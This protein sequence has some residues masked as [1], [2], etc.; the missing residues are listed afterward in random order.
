M[1]TSRTRLSRDSA[2]TTPP[3]DRQRAA[4][5]AGAVAARDERHAVAMAQ[6]HD[7]PAP[8][9]P[10]Q[11]ARQPPASRAD[12]AGRRTRRSAA[13]AHRRE[14]SNGRR[15]PEFDEKC[16]VHFRVAGQYNPHDTAQTAVW[17]AGSRTRHATA[18][19]RAR[20]SPE[21][22]PESR[23]SEASHGQAEDLTS[24]VPR[25]TGTVLTVAAAAPAL[26]SSAGRRLHHAAA[27]A[28]TKITL[29][30]NGAAKR[31]RW[32]IAGPSRRRSG[33]TS[34]SPAPRSAAIAAS[35]ARARCSL[36]GS[37][38]TRAASSRRG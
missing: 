17:I 28:R 36:T 37:L 23:W 21:S 38:C 2:I 18:S 29:T 33:I 26:R 30:L 14:R 12:A 19:Q 27:S 13:R 25:G 32:T 4:R 24:P 20:E 3:G 31:S 15:S 11:A 34:G 1:S 16:A 22:R 5:Q 6:P 7:L 35:A 8:P 10:S 9:P